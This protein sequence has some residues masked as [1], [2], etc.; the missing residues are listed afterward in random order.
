MAK[1]KKPSFETLP[2]H[3]RRLI[4]NTGVAYLQHDRVVNGSSGNS[5]VSFKRQEAAKNRLALAIQ[6]LL[7]LVPKNTGR[8][9]LNLHGGIIQDV[10]YDGTAPIE[11]VVVDWDVDGG[12]KDQLQIGDQ[13]CWVY[14]TQVA[15]YDPND[16]T[17]VAR[18]ADL[19]R[20]KVHAEAT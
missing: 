4:I 8:V 6:R 20:E 10:C 13:W 9:I 1:K 5:D 12:E 17:Q 14:Q 18:A 11:V 16:L 3:Y 19:Y 15:S 7:D 2:H